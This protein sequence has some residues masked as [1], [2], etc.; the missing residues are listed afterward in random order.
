[1]TKPIKFRTRLILYLSVV[2]CLAYVLPS[3]YYYRT[4]REEIVAE[5]RGKAVRQLDLVHWLVREKAD[6]SDAE[7]LQAWLVEIGRHMDGRIT[8]IASGGH[9]IADSQVPFGEIKSLDNHAGRPEIMQAREQDVGVAIRYSGSTLKTLLYVARNIE[10]AGAI[11]PGVLRLSVPFSPVSELLERLKYNYLV[12]LAFVLFVFVCITYWLMRQRSKPLLQITSAVNALVDSNYKQRIPAVYDGELSELAQAVNAMAKR[13]ES[14]IKVIHEKK[15]QLEAVFN[16]MQ[17]G[18]MVLD[19]RGKIQSINRALSELHLGAA[20]GL[21]RKPLEV[22]M[23]LELQ[24]AC[25]RILASKEELGSRPYSLQITLGDEKTYSVN[26][27]RPRDLTD[28]ARVIVVFHDISELKRLEKVRQDFVANVSHELRTPLTS[29]KGYSETLLAE[30]EHDPET[31]AAFLQVIL[32]NTNHM[33]K[34]VDDLLQLAR[35]EGRQSPITPLPVQ[36]DKALWAAWKECEPLAQAKGIQL[37]NHLPPT[38]VLVAADFDQLVQVFRNLLENGVKYSPGD[39]P[40]TV[41]CQLQEQ[42][43]AF[44]VRDEGPGIPRQHQQRIFERFY[45]IERHRGSESESTGLGLAICRHIIRNFG[46]KI[47]VESPHPDG[48]PGATFWF[49]LPRSQGDYDKKSI[50]SKDS[51]S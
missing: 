6:L 46:G 22:F 16:G 14:D 23:N 38:G 44:A 12:V 48:S 37:Q 43:A 35:L 30:K 8:Y 18:V 24:D 26:L 32:R 3:W 45:R 15:Q 4:L 13:I 28:S 31:L 29:I 40:L 36:A 50:S 11:S 51:E 10:P 1:M 41:S 5:T 42:K 27:V 2:V 19:S 7:S 17:E 9:V 34:M 33:V 21:G 39:K 47:W 49:S 25:D 20:Q